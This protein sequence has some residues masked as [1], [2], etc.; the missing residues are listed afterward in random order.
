MTPADDLIAAL[1]AEGLRIT[2]ARRAICEVLA[3]VDGDHLDAASIRE[4]AEAVADRSIDPSTV[5][6]T[7]DT[8]E[9]VGLAV[10]V[11]LS[12]RRSVVHLADDE[13]H[14]LTCERC[15]KVEDVDAAEVV[16]ALGPVAARHGFEVDSIHFAVVGR[17]HECASIDD[18]AS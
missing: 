3:A 17:C 7:L 1:R 5:Y 2:P 11:H 9:S 8:L 12:D 18:D 14:H 10:H 4:R 16:G 15:G 13:H 6:R